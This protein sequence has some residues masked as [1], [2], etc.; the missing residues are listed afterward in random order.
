M[1]EDSVSNAFLV[2]LLQAERKGV[3]ASEYGLVFGI[4]ELVS[5]LSCPILGKY[6]SSVNMGHFDRP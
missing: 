5:F 2:T 6:V 1:G 4:F 3:S